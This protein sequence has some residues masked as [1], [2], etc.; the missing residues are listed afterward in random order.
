M[1]YL[2]NG[3]I[4]DAVEKIGGLQDLIGLRAKNVYGAKTTEELDDKM[5]EMALVDLQKLA[6]SCGISGGGNRTVLKQK[7]RNEFMKFLRG[8]HGLSLQAS[9]TMQLKG[10]NAKERERLVHELTME[11]FKS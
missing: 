6:V 8:S 10:R 5:S 3:K 9:G 2:I 1:K 4:E 11:G 7:I